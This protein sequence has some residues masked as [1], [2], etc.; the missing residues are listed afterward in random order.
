MNLF[1]E[2]PTRDCVKAMTTYG[3]LL[4]CKSCLFVVV[5]VVC[6]VLF[7]LFF[8]LPFY[9]QL[10]IT[11]H[12]PYILYNYAKCGLICLQALTSKRLSSM[13]SSKVR[14]Y[15]F[16][17]FSFLQEIV[18]PHFPLQPNESDCFLPVILIHTLWCC[19]KSMQESLYYITT[20][21]FV[22]TLTDQVTCFK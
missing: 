1:S 20:I 4:R 3:R 21:L 15:F 16:R 14:Q 7:L 10:V 6:F 2:R 17:T 11:L 9:C 12:F 18:E 22:R 13:K 5:F 19:R 8:I